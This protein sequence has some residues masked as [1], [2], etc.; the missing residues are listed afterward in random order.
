MRQKARKSKLGRILAFMLTFALVF[1]SFTLSAAD[2]APP[3]T[4]LETV[5]ETH[6]ASQDCGA[7]DEKSDEEVIICEEDDEFDEKGD[8]KGVSASFIKSLRSA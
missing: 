4:E 5:E 2:Y 6:A 3:C 8:F 7:S 1:S